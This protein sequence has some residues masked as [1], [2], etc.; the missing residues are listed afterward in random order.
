MDLL[1][2]GNRSVY[3]RVYGRSADSPLPPIVLVHGAGGNHLVWPAALRHLPHTTVYALDLPGHGASPG[4]GCTEVSAYSE[5]VRDFVDALELPW[6]LLAGHSLGGAIALDF[7]LAYGQRLAAIA[8]IGGGARMRVSPALLDGV[9]HAFEATT[10]QIVEY[11]YH[12]SAA[13][14]LKEASLR[15]LRETD[16]HVLYGDFVACH[17][18]DATDRLAA[19]TAPT[20]LVCGQQDRMTPPERSIYLHSHLLGSELLLVEG[21]GHN[22]M[23]EQPQ[24]VTEALGAFLAKVT[25]VE[26]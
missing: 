1:T 7:A 8:I 9:L 24:A 11:S 21:A 23:V 19:L 18:F 4:P 2:I 5:I 26:R 10:A 3:Y 13:P 20:L 14:A 6:F 12:P 15:H 22:V 25:A 16:A 17:N